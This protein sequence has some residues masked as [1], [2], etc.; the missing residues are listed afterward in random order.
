MVRLLNAQRKN[1]KES[2]LK[3]YSQNII[4]SVLLKDCGLVVV[5]SSSFSSG[6]SRLRAHITCK[7]KKYSLYMSTALALP[8]NQKKIK[9][10]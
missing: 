10:T 2:S 7:S 8:V 4:L 3:I 9:I 5:L 1:F 6:F